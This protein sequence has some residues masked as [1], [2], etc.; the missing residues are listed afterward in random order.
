MHNQLLSF[1]IITT[2][3]RE[4]GDLNPTVGAA[5]TLSKTFYPHSSVRVHTFKDFSRN[6]KGLS[7]CFQEL[8]TYEK[9]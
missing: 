1:S 3:D 8:K 9:Y 5:L 2:R 7:Y 4:V 6:S